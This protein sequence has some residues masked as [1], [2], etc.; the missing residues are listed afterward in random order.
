MEKA[1]AWNYVRSKGAKNVVKSTKPVN[2]VKGT[3]PI[4]PRGSVVSSSSAST[5]YTLPSASPATFGQSSSSTSPTSPLSAQTNISPSE[6][7]MDYNPPGFNPEFAGHFNTNIFGNSSLND[8]FTFPYTPS[9]SDDRRTSH[10]SSSGNT[11]VMP[12]P[13]M[14]GDMSFDDIPI[15]IP[16][17][18][19]DLDFQN[20]IFSKNGWHNTPQIGSGMMQC[21]DNFGF[22]ANGSDYLMGDLTTFG[23]TA[24]ASTSMGMRDDLMFTTT[25]NYSMP[26]NQTYGG[27][28]SYDAG[29]F[30]LEDYISNTGINE[31]L[32]T[33]NTGFGEMG[34]QFNTDKSAAADP[35]KHLFPELD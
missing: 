21:N 29:D 1:H 23:Q 22:G 2:K 7:L 15:M 16:P 14:Q 19:E 11:P 12:T 13:T 33:D 8:P 24:Q 17:T 35:Y 5:P 30:Q 26:S 27:D 34:S 18:P 9:L 10:E 28:V 4:K 31:P 25:Q 32:F 20:S 3:V 6:S